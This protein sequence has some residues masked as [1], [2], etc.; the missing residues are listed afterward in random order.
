MKGIGAT[1]TFAVGTCDGLSIQITGEA[2]TFNMKFECSLDNIN[3]L[4]LEGCLASDMSNFS[5]L[6]AKS[7]EVVSFD[8]GAISHFRATILENNSTN[9]I[10]ILA[11]NFID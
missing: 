3:W 9:G 7:N 5:T 2:T 1:D 4:P 8:V 6:I 11:V 10:N